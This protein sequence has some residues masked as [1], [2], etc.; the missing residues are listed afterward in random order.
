MTARSSAAAEALP[1]GNPSSSSPLLFKTDREK[2]FAILT[3][4]DRNS[5]YIVST[6]ASGTWEDTSLDA[7]SLSAYR[8]DTRANCYVTRNGF[9]GKRRLDARVRQLNSIFLDVDFHEGASAD[10]DALI[11][12][13]LQSVDLA[14]AEGLLPKPTMI[15]NSGRGVHFYSFLHRSLPYRVRGGGNGNEQ[16]LSYFSRVQGQLADVL[17]GVLS[18][19]AGAKV[20]RAVFD[21]ARVSRIPDTYNTKAGRYARLV[22]AGETYYHLPELDAYKPLTPAGSAA[23]KLKPAK[24]AFRVKFDKLLLAR[25]NKVAELQEHRGFNCE[26]N[27]E[28]MA[29]VYYNTAVQVYQREEAWSRLLWFN[30]RFKSPLP[31]S[32]LEGIRRAVSSV[33]NVRG[34]RGYYILNATTIVRMLGITEK[35]AEAVRFFGSK[36]TFDRLEAKRRTAEKRRARNERII[37]LRKEGKTRQEIADE[38]G[39]S[40]GT[41]HSVLKEAGL[42]RVNKTAASAPQRRAQRAHRVDRSPLCHKVD[43]VSVEEASPEGPGK[44][45]SVAFPESSK[46]WHT[47]YGVVPSKISNSLLSQ[48]SCVWGIRFGLDPGGLRLVSHDFSF[49]R[50]A[51]GHLTPFEGYF[52]AGDWDGGAFGQNHVP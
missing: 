26:G 2:F 29:F 11:A 48:A 30:A 43:I 4:D 14:V 34:E 49:N 39:I 7:V 42:T 44:G 25:L 40:L 36:R 8:F 16:G 50:K 12:E 38:L 33:V 28:L 37:A 17:D 9:S 51:F 31:Q 1:V 46:F 20:D 27:R 5:R 18:G 3:H 19:V 21:F 52:D 41:V 15:V 45:S 47:G 6:D 23:P 10:W 32:E 24:T 13:V 35:E 22:S